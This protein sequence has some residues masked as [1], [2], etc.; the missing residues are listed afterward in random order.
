MLGTGRRFRRV[1]YHLWYEGF[2]ADGYW[3]DIGH[4]TSPDGVTWTKAAPESGAAPGEAPGAWDDGGLAGSGVIWDGV[5][6]HMWYAG[7]AAHGESNGRATP[8]HRTASRGPSACN[9]PGLEPGAAESVGSRYRTT[10]DGRLEG[11]TYRMWYAAPS[12]SGAAWGGQAG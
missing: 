12:N 8:H 4:A 1:V 6:F 7:Q 3:R 10:N 2:S 11:G 5:L 9:L